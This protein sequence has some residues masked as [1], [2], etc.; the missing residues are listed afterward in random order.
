M[1]FLYFIDMAL[2][3]NMHITGSSSPTLNQYRVF[4]TEEGIR[5][6][7][8][9]LFN[10][11]GNDL[12]KMMEAIG[13]TLHESAG[14]EDIKVYSDP[15]GA[16]IS[17]TQAPQYALQQNRQSAFLRSLDEIMEKTWKE[18]Q[19]HKDK[20]NRELPNSYQSQDDFKRDVQTAMMSKPDVHHFAT[21][22][23]SSRSASCCVKGTPD[24]LKPRCFPRTAKDDEYEGLPTSNYNGN[25]TLRRYGG[26]FPQHA[27]YGFYRKFG[28]RGQGATTSERHN[29][30]IGSA[31]KPLF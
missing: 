5:Q 7:V 24:E 13:T 20:L 6:D 9:S 23:T 8:T 14:R 19:G 3:P 15:N 2:H 25:Y 31:P 28:L 16:L 18:L 22:K 11:C 26:S 4:T 21:H 12:S 1:G 29:F 27:N 30:P 10:K 17:V